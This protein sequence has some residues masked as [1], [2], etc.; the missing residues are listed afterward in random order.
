MLTTAQRGKFHTAED[1]AKA[2]RS[3]MITPQVTNLPSG[4]AELSWAGWPHGHCT[5]LPVQADQADV[6][7]GGWSSGSEKAP[8]I[9]LPPPC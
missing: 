3:D 4:G 2:Q 5:R 9:A 8:P 6:R 1:T 7:E